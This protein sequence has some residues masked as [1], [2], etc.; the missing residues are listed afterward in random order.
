[1]LRSW[2]SVVVL[3]VATVWCSAGAQAPEPP[4]ARP[5]DPVAVIANAL[6]TYA[7]VALG[8]GAHE[9]EQDAAFRLKLL[10][11]ATV[12]A[13]ANDI[14]TECGNSRYQEVMDR[15]VAGRDIPPETLRR[16]WEDSIV[17]SPVC[18][19]RVYRDLFTVVREINATKPPER[20][21]RVLLGGPPIDWQAVRS[22]ADIVRW[23]EDRDRFVA[24]VIGRE[25]LSKGR[26]A[27]ALYGRMHVPLKNERTNFQSADYF[28]ALLEASGV[29]VF[30]IWTAIGQPSPVS[31]QPDVRSWS[32]PS[33]ALIKG[34]R[35]GAADFMAYFSSDGR[36][37]MRDGKVVPVPRTE[38]RSMRMEEL[39]D[40]VLYLGETVTYSRLPRELC[41]D[42]G[43][44]EMRYRRLALVPGGNEETA[45]LKTFC[46]AP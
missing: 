45:R 19:S 31:V 39:V 9:G 18:D 16:I 12:Q 33:L 23:E 6:R 27:L 36:L 35:L 40:A 2:A 13:A 38:W 46:A 37:A 15:Y 44:L 14:V 42:A 43:Y 8:E 25:V 26:H 20:R 17:A 34:T 28:V 21:L 10:R 29:K 32:I 1:M 5:T 3:L 7:V 41:R 24:D 4:P 30:K 11:D 22:F